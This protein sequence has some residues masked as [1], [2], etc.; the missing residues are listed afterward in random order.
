MQIPGS[1]VKQSGVNQGGASAGQGGT[2]GLA[3]FVSS[4][5][6]KNALDHQNSTGQGS[7]PEAGAANNNNTNASA[8]GQK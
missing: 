2:A 3:P 5:V 1:I 6:P 8:A 4:L 7:S